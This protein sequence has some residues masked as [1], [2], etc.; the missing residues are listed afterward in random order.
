MSTRSKLT[1]T[2]LIVAQLTLYGQTTAA[3]V[4]Q[5]V[6]RN[7]PL[8][9]RSS[10]ITGQASPVENRA[11]DDNSREMHLPEI[12]DPSG[13]LLS[14]HEEIELGAAFFRSLHGQIHINED[15]E[16]TDY[17]QR[18]GQ[19]LSANSA[20]PEHAYHFFVVME[21]NI[22]AFAGPG[23]YIGVNSGLILTTEAESELAS[24][25]AHEIAHVT[26]RHLYQAYQA[27][28]RLSLPMAAAMLAGILIGAKTGNA[29]AGEAAIIAAQAANQ[30]FQ[31]NFTRDNEAEADRVGMQNLSKSEFDPRAMPVFF[32]RM[33]QATRFAGNAL[34]EFL[35]THPV[36]VSRISDTRGRAEK[37]A[38][39]QYEDSFVYQI[40]KAKLRVLSATDP[41]EVEKY[42][43][44]TNNHGTLQQQDVTRYGLA[45]SLQAQKKYDE[46]RPLLQKLVIQHPDQP[47]FVNALARL[48][49]D[50]HRY[51]EALK[52]YD[53]ALERFPENRGIVFNYV[54]LLLL[55][56]KP[57][58]ARNLLNAHSATLA[59]STEFYELLAECYGELHNDAESHRYLAEYYY[60]NGQT[61]TAIKQMKLARQHAGNNFYINAVIDERLQALQKEEQESKEK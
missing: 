9:L 48:E 29:Q 12:G 32:E 53:M 51:P 27:A 36:T 16:T 5:Y 55:M 22:N 46:A 59:P 4:N 38:Y 19:K 52:H 23:G 21:P 18:I 15:P 45:L 34:P 14:T 54:R 41:F 47:H 42:F 3:A 37:Y 26:Q 31:I 33:Q 30:Q 43:R 57:L 7:A 10:D 40:I 11:A 56:Q 49:T 8:D 20:D 25:L 61:H 6:S 24:V 13:T 44:T 28:S 58:E 39:R 2:L 60:L 50:A 35:M 17:I 1:A